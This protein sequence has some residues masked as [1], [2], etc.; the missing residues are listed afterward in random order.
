MP[1][2]ESSVDLR[3]TREKISDLEDR[4][5]ETFQIKMQRKNNF[6]KTEQSIHEFWD[7]KSV[8]YT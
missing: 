8:T 2:I 3:E 1:L 7:I 4:L 5:I 6:K